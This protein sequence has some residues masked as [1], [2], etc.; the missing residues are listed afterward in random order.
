MQVAPIIEKESQQDKMGMK[1]LIQTVIEL[2][3]LYKINTL[4]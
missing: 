4:F 3:N 2:T 1:L